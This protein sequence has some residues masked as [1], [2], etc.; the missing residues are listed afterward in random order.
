MVTFALSCSLALCFTLKNSSP[1]LGSLLGLMVWNVLPGHQG[2]STGCETPSTPRPRFEACCV[3]VTP[4]SCNPRFCR[5]WTGYYSAARCVCHFVLLRGWHMERWS[6]VGKRN[7][8]RGKYQPVLLLKVDTHDDEAASSWKAGGRMAK[9][10]Q[11]SSHLDPPV[12]TQRPD[13][14]SNTLTFA[15]QLDAGNVFGPFCYQTSN[16]RR[17]NEAR[18]AAAPS[19]EPLIH[20][21]VLWSRR[22]G[23]KRIPWI[24]PSLSFEMMKPGGWVELKLASLMD[25]RLRLV[26]PASATKHLSL[27]L[28][29]K[30]WHLSA[31]DLK[32][33]ALFHNMTDAD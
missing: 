17:V 31:L 23:T 10:P 15:A 8:V 27:F 32:R 9:W 24:A 26:F 2:S 12:V 18:R 20:M 6:C 33:G 21:Q 30:A 4:H 28:T 1:G 3:R 19:A 5:P 22:R 11:M 7:T 16:G 29:D 14:P 25:R 13:P